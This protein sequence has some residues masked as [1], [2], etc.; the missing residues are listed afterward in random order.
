MT[1]SDMIIKATLQTLQ[2]VAASTVLAVVIGF[3]PAIIL[4][5]G[6]TI[7]LPKNLNPKKI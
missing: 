1:M 2:M 5:I 4:T 3:I 6:N 7:F